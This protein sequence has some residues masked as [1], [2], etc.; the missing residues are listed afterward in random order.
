M[1]NYENFVNE[2]LFE[3]KDGDDFTNRLLDIIEKENIEI[4]YDK[5]ISAS[6]SGFDGSYNVNVDGVEYDFSDDYTIGTVIPNYYIFFNGEKLKIS[7]STYK[8]M[9]NFYKKQHS[10]IEFPD[11]SDLRRSANKYGI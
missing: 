2:G 4:F 10:K 7:Y 8:R 3:K 11:L 6:K 1:K 9:K 5:L